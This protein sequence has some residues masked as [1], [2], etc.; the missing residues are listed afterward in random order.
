MQVADI[1]S[2]MWMSGSR[3]WGHD[4]VFNFVAQKHIFD[5]VFWLEYGQAGLRKGGTR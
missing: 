1:L 2:L 5:P 4:K 3:L